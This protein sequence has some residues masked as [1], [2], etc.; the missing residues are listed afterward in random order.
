MQ[1]G[2][3]LYVVIKRELSY[4]DNGYKVFE[5]GYPVGLF[6]SKAAAEER[7]LQLQ[8]D[9]EAGL[10]GDETFYGYN[11]EYVD[12]PALPLVYRVAEVCLH[13]NDLDTSAV[14]I[15]SVVAAQPSAHARAALLSKLS[16]L[17]DREPV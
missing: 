17:V 15:R 7:A 9:W 2:I 10:N 3:C 4:D 13:L 5:G 12:E 8:D 16:A 1:N 6:T 11:D 14:L